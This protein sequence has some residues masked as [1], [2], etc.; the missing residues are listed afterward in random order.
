MAFIYLRKPLILTALLLFCITFKLS[1]NRF[2]ALPAVSEKYQETKSQ[3]SSLIKTLGCFRGAFCS[4]K[5]VILS[6]PGSII[7]DDSQESFP[8]GLLLAIIWIGV[9][10]YRIVMGKGPIIQII[11]PHRARAARTTDNR[12]ANL[13]FE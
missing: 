8:W 6:D 5:T 3:S 4:T 9:I 11:N 12:R 2:M 10:V 13:R 1:N 7:A